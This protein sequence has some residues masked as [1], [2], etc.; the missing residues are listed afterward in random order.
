MLLEFRVR[1]FR[2]FAQE[3][4]LSFVAS[5][6]KE[7][8]DTNTAVTNVT[9]FPRAVRTAV[10]YGANASGKSNLLR[11]MQLMRGV[12]LESVLLKPDQT[13]SVQPFRLDSTL[14]VEPT[15]FEAVI[16]LQG[17]RYQYG[18]EFTPQRIVNEWLLVYQKSKPQR[19]IDRRY[20]PKTGETFEFSSSLSGQKRAWQDATRPN[21][22]FLSTA[23]QLN[24][25]QLKPLYNWFAESLV[26]LLDGGHMPFD[27]ST[28]MVRNAAE[29]EAIR[30]MMQAADI[31]I[32]AI[33]AVS[34]KSLMQSVRFDFANGTTETSR[35]ERE[36]LVPEFTHEG[37]GVSENFDFITDESQGTQK[38]F[39]LAGPLLDIIKNG[40]IL[41]IDE[42]DRSLHPLLVRQIVST[43]QD[44]SLN[45][46]GA[47]LFFTT[48]DTSL[49]DS[50]LLRRDQIWL[51][52]KT[53]NQSTE[54]VPLTEFSPR[55]GEAIEKGYLSGR[56][57][58]VP[59]LSQQLISGN[60]IGK[61]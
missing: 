55:K 15:M 33:K 41:V 8:I 46:S 43:F 47:Q 30:S 44:T 22:L 60:A 40:K 4:V 61:K 29:Q 36:M 5:N 20:D 53:V 32:S 11:A 24:S 35:E 7:L 21:A 6:D 19:W 39:A 14:R 26:I 18:F 34:K 31:A 25:E 57:G 3:S 38:L 37:N 59:I 54:L 45:K 51:T 10:V 16:L 1:N 23:V 50:D 58:G 9:A 17:V 13:F 27:F 48:H 2:S 42:L 28:E 52:D 49:L 12:V 56:Y